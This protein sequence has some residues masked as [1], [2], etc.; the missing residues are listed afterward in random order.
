MLFRYGVALPYKAFDGGVA[1]ARTGYHC[2]KHTFACLGIP[3][4]EKHLAEAFC[5]EKIGHFHTVVGAHVG[6]G[7]V[8]PYLA[9]LRQHQTV[10][11]V[12]RLLLDGQQHLF[13]VIYHVSHV[14]SPCLKQANVMKFCIRID[15]FEYKN[16][17]YRFL[18]DRECFCFI[19]EVFEG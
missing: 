2:R 18:F 16:L 19:P 4:V 3:H 17:K 11:C 14:F 5:A 9:K 1:E 10:H 13:D 12:E 8:E 6:C 7:F 15:F